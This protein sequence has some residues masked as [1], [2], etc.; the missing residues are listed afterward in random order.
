MQPS[1]LVFVVVIGLW[2]AY[3]TQSWMRRREHLQ[4]ARSLERYAEAIAVLQERPIIATSSTRSY[5]VSPLRPT[6]PAPRAEPGSRATRAARSASRRGRTVRALS[7]VL[8][9]GATV[10]V[11]VL[12][13][14]RMLPLWAPAIGVALLVLDLG[15][16]R[17]AAKSAVTPRPVPVSEGGR[18]RGRESAPVART[19]R[20]SR[21]AAAA[22]A[23]WAPVAPRPEPLPQRAVVE[24]AP[25]PAARA[26]ERP[27]ER[28]ATYVPPAAATELIPAVE[29]P[30]PAVRTVAA[31]RTPITPA[32]RP[33]VAEVAPTPFDVRSYDEPPLVVVEAEPEPLAP[34]QWRPVPVPLPTYALKTAAPRAAHP[35]V[36]A[37]SVPGEDDVFAPVEIEDEFLDEPV[38]LR[39][40][41]GC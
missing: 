28:T 10:A 24:P 15:W 37:G 31:D 39:R 8:T 17:H 1:S 26:Q 25:A 14:L 34:G 41:V 6:G 38:P 19:T 12:A 30:A 7:L 40:V 5:A 3:L 23:E 2:A 27:A 11:V 9:L 32:P 21:R 4:T 16:L 29:L 33:R 13:A 36:A 18:H 22:E 20:A 35:V